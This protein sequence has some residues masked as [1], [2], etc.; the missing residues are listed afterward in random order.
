ME[1]YH[2]GIRGMKWG[3]RRYQNKDGSLTPEGRIRY[4][5]DED[6]DGHSD[7]KAAFDKM[8]AANSNSAKQSSSNS[9][10]DKPEEPKKKTV[11]EMSDD[12]LR[13][14]I[15]RIRLEQEYRN[16]TPQKVSK[17]K[18]ILD[19]VIVPAL[20]ETSKTL[21]KDYSLKIGKE[22]FGLNEKKTLSKIEKLEKQ[23]KEL[24][25]ERKI[26]DLKKGKK[27]NNSEDEYSKKLERLVKN[28]ENEKKLKG[29]EDDDGK[30]KQLKDLE[31]EINIIKKQ[32]ELDE[33]LKEEDED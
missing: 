3:K 24:D 9:S 12:E 17:G 20:K 4:R 1:L 32:K 10:T 22:V 16:L 30:A 28:Y 25:L 7:R 27:D 26:S 14:A 19:D 29:F 21:I 31:N 23:Y 6:G 5:D 15:A 33:L 8:R 18:K 13:Q 11:S 2:W